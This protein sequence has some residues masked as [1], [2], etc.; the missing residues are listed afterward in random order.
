MGQKLIKKNWSFK[1]SH[2]MQTSQLKT[3][4]VLT[5]YPYQKDI[6]NRLF[7]ASLS[8]G[9]IHVLEE[10]IHH[11]LRFSIDQL[12]EDLELEESELIPILN[13]FE[14]IKLLKF[15]GK[16]I[17]VDKEV[18]KYFE[19]QIE[20][21][22]DD[23]EPNLEF[24]QNFLSQVPIHL[25]PDWYAI[26]RSSDNI[27]ASIIEKHFLTPKIFRQYIA[28]LE[29]DV[30]ILKQLIRDVYEAP[31]FKYCANELMKKY[32]IN[33]KQFEEYL[34]LLEY[35]FVCCLTYEQKNGK[36]EGIVTPF[37]EWEDFLRFEAK[38]TLL[39][40]TSKILTMYEEPFGFILD[41]NRV[42]TICKTTKS[43]FRTIQE[44]KTKQVPELEK[45]INKLKEL[46]WMEQT[47]SGQ[48]IPTKAGLEWASKSIQAQAVDLAFHPNNKLEKH[49]DFESL[50]TVR[51]LRLIEK[52]LRG[53]PSNKWI[54]IEQFLKSFTAP[55]GDKENI[56]LKNKGKKWRYEIPTYLEQEKE[57]I[58]A[59]ILE[60]LHQL[61]VVKVGTFE[62]QSCFSLTDY[63]QHY[64]H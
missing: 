50:V 44:S 22:C 28:E 43:T 7:L 30:P 56:S 53:I 6:D 62:G 51:N 12:T 2:L 37:S 26:P 61:G 42:L 64:I 10:I 31:D 41:L 29:F 55:L 52:N 40:S 36:W 58:Q 54:T 24:F 17:S 35:H 1:R 20:K 13:K 8:V 46:G 57:F 19:F 27:V 63:G 33:R 38:K 59:I 4:V 49:S 23:F 25:L 11:S 34:L 32:E 16:I 21:F 9:E 60:R 5:D 48:L 15:D 14:T 45:V 39:P 47:K 18:R 3:K